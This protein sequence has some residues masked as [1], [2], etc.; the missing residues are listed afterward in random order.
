MDDK[1]FESYYGTTKSEAIT[2][3][4]VKGMKWGIRKEAQRSVDAARSG[5]QSRAAYATREI[6]EAE[7][8]SLSSKP[9]K[10][11]SDFKRVSGSSAPH[12]A[13]VAYVTKDASDHNRYKALLS[14]AGDHR[15][16]DRKFDVTVKTAREA[17]SPSQKERIDTYIKTLGSDIP[18]QYPGMGQKGRDFVLQSN[19][20]LKAL[21]DRELG[22]KTYQQFSQAQVMK[23]PIH[24]VYFDKI[25]KSGYNALIDDADKDLMAKLPIIL[26][27]NQA[28]AKVTQIK[29]ITE[30]ELI[31]ARLGL[32]VDL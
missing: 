20:H 24:D 15:L 6:T 5:I 8:N 23:L 18:G 3:H 31:D 29:P 10:L 19:P 17:I 1:E 32:K 22:L 9:I 25:K 28:G 21:S 14:P 16:M 27:P 2:H 7:Y 12:L 13:N 4:G 11:G 26:F 30:D